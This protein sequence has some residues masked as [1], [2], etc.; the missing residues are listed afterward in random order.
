MKELELFINLASKE[1]ITKIIKAKG[2]EVRGFTNNFRKAPTAFLKNSLKQFLAKSGGK[3][4][5]RLINEDIGSNAKKYQGYDYK[6]FIYEMIK[7]QDAIPDN[8]AFGMFLYL[9]PNRVDDYLSQFIEN[10]EENK[11]IFDLE[12]DKEEITD[13]NATNIFVNI[14]KFDSLLD[15]FYKFKDEL[16]EDLLKLIDNK[17][18]ID[19]CLEEVQTI[20]WI[21]F[22]KLYPELI[23]SYDDKVIYYSYLVGNE[24]EIKGVN[25]DTLLNIYLIMAYEVFLQVEQEIRDDYGEKIQF[26]IKEL[27]RFE[28][29]EEN[30]EKDKKK[31]KR[32]KKQVKK[33]K[34]SLKKLKQNNQTLERKIKNK[35]KDYKK[36]IDKLNSEYQTK[37][38]KLKDELDSSVKVK[39]LLRKWGAI[40]EESNLVIIDKSNS[41]L[42]ELFLGSYIYLNPKNNLENIEEELKDNDVQD[43]TVIINRGGINTKELLH[44]EKVLEDYQ[45]N[46]EIVNAYSPKDFIKEIIN[47]NLI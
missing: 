23:K 8:V 3:N 35:E 13:D 2:V 41:E 34:V 30:Y 39:E 1:E 36:E 14:N 15:K 7:N 37:Y 43:Y 44:L 38:E 45:I 22:V 6:N 26:I 19:S 27:D 47:L 31:L 33:R 17:D 32:L 42:Y 40:E 9:Y 29:I 28:E 20:S 4:F 11:Y 5:R 46:K 25:D 18:L 16:Y 12:L 10:V 24:V 21:E